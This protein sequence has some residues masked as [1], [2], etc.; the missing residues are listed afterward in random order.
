[1]DD[2]I[3]VFHQGDSLSLS[4]IFFLAIIVGQARNSIINVYEKLNVNVILKASM[5]VLETLFLFSYQHLFIIIFSLSLSR[6][7]SSSFCSYRSEK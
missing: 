7:V 1:M 3:V 5:L 4:L 6:L 2:L